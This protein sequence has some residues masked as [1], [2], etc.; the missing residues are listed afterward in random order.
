M[1]SP[2]YMKRIN[3]CFA[4]LFICNCAFSQAGFNKLLGGNSSERFYDLQPTSDGGYVLAGKSF[5]SNNGTLTGYFGNGVFDYWIVKLDHAGNQQWQKLLGGSDADEAFTILQ[6]SD[7]GYIVAGQSQSSNTGTLS[8]IISNGNFDYWIIKLDATGNLLWQR[9]YGGNG[10]DGVNSIIQ[11][12]DGGYI[13]AGTSQ[14]SGGGTLTGMTVFSG[15]NGWLMKLDDAG[16]VQWQL[17]LGGSGADAIS[18]IGLTNDGNVILCGY[19]NSTSNGTL[20]GVPFHGNY[21]YWLLK[22][23]LSGAILWQKRYGGT[24]D[25]QAFE[26]Q[27]TADNGFVLV[28]LSNSSNSGTLIGQTGN[29]SSD[30]LVLKVDGSG[31]LQW[32]T[33]LG[34]SNADYG[35]SIKQLADGSYLMGGSTSSSNSGTLTGI[36]SNGGGDNWMVKLFSTGSIHWQKLL[37]GSNTEDVKSIIV[38]A[39]NHFVLAGASFSSNSGTLSGIVSS[40]QDDG[41]VI[42]QSLL[43]ALPVLMTDFAL[44]CNNRGEVSL[45]WTTTHEVDSDH[46]EIQKS[47]NGINWRYAGKVIAKGNSTSTNY[48]DFTDLYS[49]EQ[50]YRLKQVY[51]NGRYAYSVVQ[52]TKCTADESLALYPIPANHKLLMKLYAD[53]GEDITIEVIDNSGRSITHRRLH[54][55]KGV[56]QVEIALTGMPEGFYHLK[57]TGKSI[58]LNKPF[59]IAR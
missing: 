43:T 45:K 56:N 51:R 31:N 34:G 12:P 11:T 20:T 17:I 9:L 16:N 1:L 27:Q 19:S 25:D 14:S 55:K 3:L 39:D 52:K 28:G 4:L 58:S 33:L 57:G 32:R 7:G 44:T 13:V 47:N 18:D 40:G 24:N 30:A 53:H 36:V 46:Y 2:T 59:L 50:L 26:V 41:W 54:V 15:M 8:E 23:D 42:K 29:G 48:Y 21:D 37:G 22:M 38:T 35:F 49:S 10:V 6:T 5:S